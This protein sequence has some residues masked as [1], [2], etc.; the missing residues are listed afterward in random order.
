MPKTQEKFGNISSDSVRAKT[1]KDWSEWFTLLDGDNA[2][3]LP[4]KQ[5][6]ELLSTKYEVPA[7][8]CQ[9]VT[10]GYE[11]ARGLRVIHQKADGFSAGASK[12]LSA[13]LSAL[14]AACTDETLRPK[15]IGSKTY[16]ITKATPN[17][18]VRIAWGKGGATRVDFGLYAK[19]KTKSQ[20]TI[21]H[22]KLGSADEVAQMKIYWGKALD[23]LKL[24]LEK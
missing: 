22:A 21:Q 15:W 7:W 9:M 11:Q 23:K 20:L 24:L 19:G 18:S 2:A 10:V 13:P 12:T 16:A 3:A 5:I 4:H 1:G 17:K 6:A 14:Y 8:W